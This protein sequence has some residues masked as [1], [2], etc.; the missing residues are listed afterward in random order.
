MMCD[1][2]PVHDASYSFGLHGVAYPR[3]SDVLKVSIRDA[4]FLAGTC[5]FVKVDH[6]VGIDVHLLFQRLLQL[7]A[8]W[9]F[10][11]LS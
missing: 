9:T 7:G 2:R 4:K 8:Q 10:G 1:N 11:V 3:A 6:T 5:E